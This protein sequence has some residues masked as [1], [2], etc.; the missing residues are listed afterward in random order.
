MNKRTLQTLTLISALCLTFLALVTFGQERRLTYDDWYG[1]VKKILAD[2][3]TGKTVKLRAAIPATRRGLE[4][5]DGSLNT[6][7]AAT[8]TETL[9]QSGDEV[10]IKSFKVTD[11]DIELLLSKADEKRKSRFFSWPKKP[12]ISLRFSHELTV[13]DLTIDTINGWLAQAMDVTSL[14]TEP[15]GSAAQASVAPP[16]MMPKE[17]STKPIAAKSSMENSQR[18]PTPTIVSDLPPNASGLAELA[19]ECSGRYARVYIDDAYS[20]VAPRTVKLRPGVHSVLVMA[21]GYKAWEQK[22]FIP[23]GKAS[24]IKAELQR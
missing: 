5:V 1:D 6:G 21:D 16:P 17:A 19:V 13:K 9:A 12:R 11:T 10:T 14:T 7:N 22:L 23:G 2:H 24:V 15:A 4:L 3:Y 18:L 8:S 20:G